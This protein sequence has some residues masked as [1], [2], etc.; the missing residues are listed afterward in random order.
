MIEGISRVRSIRASPYCVRTYVNQTNRFHDETPPTVSRYTNR[1][2]RT[3]PKKREETEKEGNG[4]RK[5]RRGPLKYH[6]VEKQAVISTSDPPF[7]REYVEA[8][9]TRGSLS[10]LPRMIDRRSFESRQTK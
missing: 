8:T 4:K 1:V 9:V 10:R 6:R 3:E 7:L 5:H 2:I